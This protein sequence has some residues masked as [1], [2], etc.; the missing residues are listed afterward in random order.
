MENK[1]FIFAV[2]TLISTIIGAGIF[3]LPYAFAKAGFWPSL[4]IFAVLA[5]VN[6]VIMLMYGEVM[7]RTLGIH[8]EA[9]G[10]AGTYLGKPGRVVMLLANLT[11]I[12]GGMLIYII[13]G[14]DFLRSAFGANVSLT[15]LVWGVIFFGICAC[16]VIMGLR[17]VSK[18]DLIFTAAFIAIVTVIFIMAVPRIAA[19]NFSTSDFTQILFPFG[20]IIFSLNG[21]ASITLLN[22]ILKGQAKKLSKAI[23]WGGLIATAINLAFTIAILG[24][25]GAQTTPD[26]I[27]TVQQYLPPWSPLLLAVFGLVAVGTSFFISG[28]VLRNMYTFDYKMKRGLAL[29]LTLIFPIVFFFFDVSGFVA[30]ISFVGS[31]TGGLT[32]IIYVLMYRR[33]RVTG[34]RKPEFQIN[35]PVWIQGIVLFVYVLAIIYE[36]IRLF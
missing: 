26:S 5:M 7:L 27:G 18:A 32:G 11:G 28:I 23:L 12:Y 14:A 30:T 15:P 16:F 36:V 3:A 25:G 8:H 31:I 9:T 10:Y 35:F 21:A 24:L 20:V 6:I 2:A 34:Q 22:N 29:L 33:A 1:N 4:I 17:I 19:V 13:G